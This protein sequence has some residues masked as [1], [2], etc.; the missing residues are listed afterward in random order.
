MLTIKEHV[1]LATYTTFK[2]G[3]N[4]RFFC[5]VSSTKELH[6]ACRIAREKA[7][8]LL[9]L[10]G[11]SNMLVSDSGFGGLV[12]KIEIKGIEFEERGEIVQ[13]RI[14]AGED[15]DYVVAKC[16][17]QGYGGIEN[18]SYIPGTVGAA[19]V[20]NI[21]AYGVEIGSVIAAVRAVNYENGEERIFS[22]NECRFAYRDSFFKTPGGRKFIIT[23]VT[24]ELQKNCPLNMTYKD[25]AV[26]YEQN[27][28]HPKT[29]Q[30]VRDAVIMIRKRKLP[31]LSRFGTA[32]SFFKNPIISEKHFALLKEKYPTLPSYS[33]SEGYVKV[34]LAWILDN[35]CGIKGYKKG[36][37]GYL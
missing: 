11:G 30:G 29:L 3:G 36:N 15:W 26:F 23:E 17:S 35:V 2:I 33:A 6:E 9:V 21:G 19:P 32:G 8:P 34:P 10:G 1:P 25:V 27:P 28:A 20:Q 12:I 37:S 16:V 7:L 13:V 31:D 4:A 22:R 18:L 24:L 5:A 14:G